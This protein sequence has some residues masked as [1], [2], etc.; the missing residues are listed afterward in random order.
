MVFHLGV[1]GKPTTVDESRGISASLT[2][3]EATK[4]L[5]VL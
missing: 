1:T 3:P 5:S 4:T 2:S